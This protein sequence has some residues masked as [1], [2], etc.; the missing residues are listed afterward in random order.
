MF[1][2]LLQSL[3]PQAAARPSSNADE[4]LTPGGSGFDDDG[5]WQPGVQR[6]TF[7]VHAGEHASFGVVTAQV[8]KHTFVNET[9]NGWAM[10]QRDGKVGHGGPAQRVYLGRGI[11]PGSTVTVEA[12]RRAR[13]L[14]FIVDGHNAGANHVW[15]VQAPLLPLLRERERAL[16]H[17][18]AQLLQFVEP[19]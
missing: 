4:P 13:T 6:W 2:P 10:F 14:S 17:S 12:D 8:D 19:F 16:F 1:R 5:D 15:V 18:R 3:E 7:K 9:K 11:A